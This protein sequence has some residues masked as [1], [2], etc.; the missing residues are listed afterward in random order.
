MMDDNLLN[1][2]RF[3]LLD[4]GLKGER[5]EQV[6]IALVKLGLELNPVQA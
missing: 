4:K 6:S 2:S 3:C 1:I 5:N